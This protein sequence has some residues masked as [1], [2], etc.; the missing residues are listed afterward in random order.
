MGRGEMY[1]SIVQ[2]RLFDNDSKP[3]ILENSKKEVEMP[4]N[5]II[6]NELPSVKDS[7]N[8]INE[9]T[10]EKVIIF[11]SDKSFKEYSPNE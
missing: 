7:E 4:E 8:R 3:I 11:Y 9:K 5:Q 10:I 2:Q 1:K 6:T